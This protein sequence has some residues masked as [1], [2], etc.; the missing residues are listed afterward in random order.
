VHPL[1]AGLLIS[2]PGCASN[3]LTISVLF[4]YDAELIGVHPSLFAL[5]KSIPGCASNN[6][7]ISV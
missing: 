6:L 7:T 3:N 5:L 4:Q 2:I 1:S